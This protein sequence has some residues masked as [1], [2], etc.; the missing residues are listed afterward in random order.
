MKQDFRYQSFL[1]VYSFKDL[2]KQ[3]RSNVVL[4][5]YPDDEGV[6]NNHGRPGAAKGPAQILYYLGKL[7]SQTKAARSIAVMKEKPVGK[8]IALRHRWAEEKVHALLRKSYRVITL[9]GGHDYAFPDASAFYQIYKGKILNIDAHL[10][11]RSMLNSKINSGTAFSRFSEKFGGSSIVQWGIQPQANSL[12]L[13]S[14]AKKNKMK[15]L[16]D[17]DAMPRIK[18]KL[19]LSICLDAVAT[20]RGVSAPAILGLEP[21]QIVEAVAY[22]AK[23]SPWMGIYESAPCYDPVNEDSARLGALLIFHYLHRL[24]L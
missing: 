17:L 2:V 4:L 21:R 20:I 24:E 14:Y 6:R 15:V 22:Y 23:V 5:C 8:S 9:G 18:G 7:N 13:F 11:V 19:G 10:D 16:S 3:K 12:E 1:R